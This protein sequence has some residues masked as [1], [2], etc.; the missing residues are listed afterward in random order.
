MEPKKRTFL[1]RG[2]RKWEVDFGLDDAGVR[3]RP[4]FSTEAEADEA[5]KLFEKEEKKHGDI[6]AR[7]SAPER[8][9]IV[10][11]LIEIAAAKLTLA[12]VWIR[13]KSQKEAVDK[14]TAVSTKEFADV[15]AEFRKRK[16]A[17]GKTVKYVKDTGDFFLKFGAGRAQ[18]P[19]HEILADELEQWL[20]DQAKSK[21]WS[22]STKRAYTLAFSNLWEV[23]LAKGWAT[24][25]IVD[26][27]EPI[28]KPGQIVRIYANKDTLN[29]MA[30]A[31]ASPLTQKIIAPLALGLFG[32]MRPE[33]INSTKAVEAGLSGK[34]LFGW[35]DIDLENGLVTVRVEIAKTGDQRTIRLQPTAVAWL[36]LA[37]ELDN[38]LPPVN[39]RRLIDAGCESIGLGE[40]IRDGLRKNCCTHLRAVYKNDY[41]VVKDCGNSVRILL[42]HY[43]G[44]HVPESVSLAHWQ[45][46]PEKVREYLK[47]Q[48]WET[49]LKTAKQ[50]ASLALGESEEQSPNGTAKRVD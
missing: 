26:R 49:V 50:R 15:V 16:L 35:H 12:E 25:N 37:K 27:L 43:A 31:M 24:V 45:I 14:Q 17:A 28:K 38:P 23:A 10:A 44:L 20:E 39:E 32:C 47:S 6:W 36:K 5:I 41:D 19:V 3:R 29:I 30:A 1:K 8:R 33:E 2:R 9:T 46:T 13:F 42:K 4:F 21:N 48:N 34:R 22:L 40:W 18:Q 7:L 11:T